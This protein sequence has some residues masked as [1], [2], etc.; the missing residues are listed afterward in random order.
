MA[1]HPPYEPDTMV[2]IAFRNEL[3]AREW[4]DDRRVAKL[5]GNTAG[6]EGAAYVT[7]ARARGALLG[8]WSERLHGFVY[9]D[10]QFD[11]GGA[12]RKDVARLLAV[13]PG[14]NDHGGWRRAFWMYSPHALL[15][16]QT[17]A[18]VFQDAPTRVITIAQEE[19]SGD[20]D[21]TW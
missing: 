17:P 20:P 6:P 3:L 19:F 16:D 18:D 4:P 2:A 14:D 5:T 1:D 11:R 13:L 21:M 10:F 15:D 9:P 7:Q 12:I 8:V